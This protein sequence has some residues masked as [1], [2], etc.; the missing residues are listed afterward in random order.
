MHVSPER[1]AV[2]LTPPLAV[3]WALCTQTHTH[4]QVWPRQEITS[5][6]FYTYVYL[7]KRVYFST[8]Y[9]PAFSRR[10]LDIFFFRPGSGEPLLGEPIG[11]IS[12][13]YS[14]GWP[15]GAV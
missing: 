8:S 14:G 7:P 13:E 15:R 6:I 12:G 2:V 3:R 5:C 9:P 1:G 4:T 11:V 10:L